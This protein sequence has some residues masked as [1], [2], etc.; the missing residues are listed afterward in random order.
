MATT[1]DILSRLTELAEYSGKSFERLELDVQALKENRYRPYF[2]SAGAFLVVVLGVMGYIYNLET[3]L[4]GV[5]FNLNAQVAVGDERLNVLADRL[6]M[7]TEATLERWHNHAD[8][9]TQLDEGLR[10]LVVRMLDQDE[11]KSELEEK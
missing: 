7:R 3:R 6:A 9:H 5:L 2:A 4:T 1:E 8:K 10:V 11:K